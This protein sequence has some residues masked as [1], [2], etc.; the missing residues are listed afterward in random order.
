MSKIS[1]GLICVNGHEKYSFSIENS[2]FKN[3]KDKKKSL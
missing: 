3:D 2:I 1:K